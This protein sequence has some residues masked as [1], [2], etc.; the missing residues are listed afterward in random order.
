ML[1][2]SGQVSD[3]PKLRNVLLFNRGGRPL[4]C[5]VGYGQTGGPGAL[6][7]RFWVLELE[8]R[9]G[10]GEVEKGRRP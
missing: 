1:D 2:I 4:S 3:L 5:C 7:L 10:A 9:E 6:E 8:V